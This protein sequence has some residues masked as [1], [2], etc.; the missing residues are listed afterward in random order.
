M[1]HLQDEHAFS[2]RRACRLIGCNRRS[3]RHISKR[4]DD[5]GLREAMKQLAE[6]KP[7]WGY[8][9]LHGA[10]RLGG[11]H[12][13]HKKAHR[14]YREEKREEKLALRK[15]GKKRLKCEKRGPVPEVTAPGQRWIRPGAPGLHP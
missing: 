8:R 5:T 11:W 7:A 4:P 13:N 15:R 10:L 9:M 3:A 2:Q 12:F 14:L 6:A 1:R